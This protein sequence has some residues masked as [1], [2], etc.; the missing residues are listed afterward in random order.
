MGESEGPH[1]QPLESPQHPQTCPDAVSTLHRDEA[2]YLSSL[3]SVNN[4]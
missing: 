2:C 4:L 3:V 1:P